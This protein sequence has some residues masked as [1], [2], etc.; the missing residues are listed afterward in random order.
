MSGLKSILSTAA[1]LP[2]STWQWV[3]A[4][5]SPTVR[6]GSDSGGTDICSGFIGSNPLEPVR[7]GELQGPML[8]VAARSFDDD[9][10]EIFDAVGELVI[11]Q[12]MPSMP[13]HLWGDTEDEQRYRESYFERF[14]VVEQYPAGVWAQGDWVTQTSRGSFIVH[15]RSDATL[16]RD[17]VRLG[18]AEL[19][20][21]LGEV[22]EIKE[23]TVIGVEQ[24]DG[25]YWMP[26]FVQLVDDVKL[27]S[28]LEQR[29][30]DTLRTQASARHVPDEIIQ[31]S[32][33]P[34]THSGKRI[35]VPL[36][37]L[38]S[39]RDA[40]SA[41]NQDAVVNPEALQEFVRLAEQRLSSQS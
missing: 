21:A 41:I 27:T 38:F 16:N 4:H 15:G 20:A 33:I 14:P 35:E 13:T 5:V 32:A 28:E 11:T 26:L 36:K 2:E 23:S 34:L 40:A 30:N 37:K 17:G 39:G 1:P 31:V 29:I 3:H 8:G 6:L 24:P 18:T 10:R 25:G 19:Y 12:P 22:A 9:G 7:L